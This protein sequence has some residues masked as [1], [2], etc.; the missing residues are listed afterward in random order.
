VSRR[1][2]PLRQTPRDL[3][4]YDA[5]AGVCADP[6]L[7]EL[8]LGFGGDADACARCAQPIEVGRGGAYCARCAA[9]LG[10]A[11]PPRDRC[12]GWWAGPRGEERV[13]CAARALAPR[14]LTR[15][16]ACEKAQKKA[17]SRSAKQAARAERARIAAALAQGEPAARVATCMHDG[18]DV[19]TG[20]A[21]RLHC[22]AHSEA[23]RSMLAGPGEHACPRCGRGMTQATHF[24]ST[25]Q[26]GKRVCLHCSGAHAKAKGPGGASP[27][28]L[29]DALLRFARNFLTGGESA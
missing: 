1:P 15:C 13:A 2:D 20:S 22:A 27:P 28:P 18:C 10:V 19:D 5:E 17:A 4:S 24:T 29:Q 7:A 16:S 8:W 6:L 11:E 12:E 26:R 25:D 3:E 9:G 21:E 23:R 14:G